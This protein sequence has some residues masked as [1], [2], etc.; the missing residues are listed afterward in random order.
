M[1]IA[2]DPCPRIARIDTHS[3]RGRESNWVLAALCDHERHVHGSTHCISEFF[4]LHSRIAMWST[5]ACSPAEVLSNTF[6]QHATPRDHV[7]TIRRN[8]TAPKKDCRS[9]PR[10]P[11]CLLHESCPM[12]PENFATAHGRGG[13]PCR[14]YS[15]VKESA[16]PPCHL[17]RIPEQAASMPLIMKSTTV[18]V[19][20]PFQ[21]PDT[22]VPR[23]DNA[24]VMHIYITYI[25]M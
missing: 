5:S 25:H 11:S 18:G 14:G 23:I 12:R 7:Y 24:P 1:R 6:Q 22:C 16:P 3:R 4:T 20:V 17:T 8:P 19:G 10:G 15:L 9:W 13:P 21:E 2:H